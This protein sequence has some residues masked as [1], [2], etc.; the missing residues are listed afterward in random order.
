MDV[1]G[2][3]EVKRDLVPT[4]GAL[5]N[6]DVQAAILAEVTERLKPAQDELLA[7]V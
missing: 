5:L 1:I 6:A 2:E 4:S 7:G 3:Y